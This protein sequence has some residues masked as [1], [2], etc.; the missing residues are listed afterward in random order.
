[1]KR[2]GRYAVI[3]MAAT[4][5]VPAGCARDKPNRIPFN[6]VTFKS[7]TKAVDKKVSRADFTST[8][9]KV[10]QSLEGAKEAARH[11]GTIYCVT[12]YGNSDVVWSVGPDIETARLPIVDDTI[13][14]RGKC[15]P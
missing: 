6:G 4:I 14:F 7:K 12:N 8:I 13:T 2:V 15:D 1:M 5:L 9:Y 11:Q 3:L 10:S